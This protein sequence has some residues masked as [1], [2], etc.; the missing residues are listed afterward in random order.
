MNSYF[1]RITPIIEKLFV[2]PVKNVIQAQSD[3]SSSPDSPA[4]SVPSAPRPLTMS[5]SSSLTQE[6]NNSDDGELW[7]ACRIGDLDRVKELLSGR[8][9][10]INARDISGRRSTPLHFAA[11]FGRK[12]VVEYL[13]SIGGDC[14]SADEGGLIPLHNAC[15]FGHGEVV[16]LLIEAGSDVN[17]SDAWGYAPLHEAA[18]KG[19]ADVCIGL[20]QSGARKSFLHFEK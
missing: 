16:R 6:M 12:D 17:Q 19:K 20:L 2:T 1:E 18:I 15:S 3:G 8:G 10:S 9:S 4:V 5:L 13:L 7:E 14:G 11:G